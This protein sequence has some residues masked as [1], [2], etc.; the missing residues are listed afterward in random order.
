VLLPAESLNDAQCFVDDMALAALRASL[1]PAH[2]V[3][4]HEL[5]AALG[6]L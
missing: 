1:A 6:A 5:G 2:V 3:P 4:A